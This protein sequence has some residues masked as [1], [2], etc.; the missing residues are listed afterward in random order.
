MLTAE[1]TGTLE[2]GNGERLFL[3]RI[4]AKGR[5]NGKGEG[6]GERQGLEPL[7]V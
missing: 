4:Y 7:S 5:E 2:W 6:L 1:K 3:P